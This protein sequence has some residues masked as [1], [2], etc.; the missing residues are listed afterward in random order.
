MG[1]ADLAP[2]QENTRLQGQLIL[3]NPE[4][5]G[6]PQDLCEAVGPSPEGKAVQCAVH[7]VMFDGFSDGIQ[8]C[9]GQLDV[10]DILVDRV[11]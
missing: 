4:E 7:R 3:G 9:C 8:P 11:R 6:D 2:T 10:L 5:L 1:N